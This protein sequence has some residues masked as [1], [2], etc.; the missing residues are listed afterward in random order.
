M[1]W[2]FILESNR[3]SKPGIPAPF[4]APVEVDSE[5]TMKHQQILRFGATAFNFPLNSN[6]SNKVNIYLLM[7]WNVSDS[8]IVFY[9]ETY[10]PSTENKV[11]KIPLVPLLNFIASFSNHVPVVGALPGQ[12]VKLVIEG[13]AMVYLSILIQS[14]LLRYLCFLFET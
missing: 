10:S 12:R 7:Q 6:I 2:C 8:F 13:L 5:V 1:L 11:C 14:C 3:P 4:P 9:I